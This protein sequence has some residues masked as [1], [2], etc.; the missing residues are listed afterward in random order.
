MNRRKT[1]TPPRF[2]HKVVSTSPWARA[3]ANFVVA[4][5][6]EPYFRTPRT[7]AYFQCFGGHGRAR[8]VGPTGR[9][10]C[11]AFAPTTRWTNQ[12]SK[13]AHARVCSASRLD[14][15]DPC[16]S[17][18]AHEPDASQRRLPTLSTPA[19]RRNVR[20]RGP[21]ARLPTLFDRYARAGPIRGWLWVTPASFFYDRINY[22]S[23]TI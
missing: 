5:D 20:G 22:T 12:T 19:R 11:R 14:K 10:S 6:P 2:G 3:R 23:V 15:C 1:P 7:E 9:L 21:R 4:D 16:P 13:P 8:R 17:G 18:A